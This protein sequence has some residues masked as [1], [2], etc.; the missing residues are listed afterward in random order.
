MAQYC[1]LQ[2]GT[3]IIYAMDMGAWINTLLFC[4]CELLVVTWVYGRLVIIYKVTN[5]NVSI[6]FFIRNNIGGK[7]A[8]G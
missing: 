1:V 2:I 5:Y 4:I 8:C 3:L 7:P 6:R